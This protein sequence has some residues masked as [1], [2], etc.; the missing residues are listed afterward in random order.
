MLNLQ[1]SHLNRSRLDALRADEPY[2]RLEPFALKCGKLAGLRE[3]DWI[4]L[5][6]EAP[7]LELA[8]DGRA[9]AEVF[10]TREGVRIHS[11]VEDDDEP[12]RGRCRIEARLTPLP[13]AKV[14]EGEELP[15]AWQAVEQIHLYGPEGLLAVAELI[16]YDE[17]YA[18]RI[19]ELC[20][21]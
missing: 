9:L 15:L 20:H 12:E 5:G 19:E 1:L 10:P 16:R 7:G 4:D 14:R 11:L 13:G 6:R 18:L 21:G 17:G 3:G 8:R 2:L